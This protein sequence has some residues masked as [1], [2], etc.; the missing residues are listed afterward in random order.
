MPL[1]KRI[2]RM[3]VLITTILISIVLSAAFALAASRI[4]VS[5]QSN[6]KI[7]HKPEYIIYEEGSMYYAQAANGN[8]A[9]SSTN[10]ATVINSAFGNLTSGRTWQET[11]Y[12]KG[13]FTMTS[14]IIIPSYTHFVLDGSIYAGNGLNSFILINTHGNLA[15]ANDQFI[16][17]EGGE[18]YGNSANQVHLGAVLDMIYWRRCTDSIV[19]NAYFYD[20][21]EFAVSFNGGDNRS[22]IEDCKFQ[23][24]GQSASKGAIFMSTGTGDYQEYNEVTNCVIN[25]TSQNGIYW[26]SESLYGKITGCTIT[27]YCRIAYGAGI[28]V[29]GNGTIVSDCNVTNLH[30]ASTFGEVGIGCPD[31]FNAC[32]VTIT[33]CVITNSSWDGMLLYGKNWNVS[34]NYIWDSGEYGMYCAGTSNSI[35]SSNQI[36]N[37]TLF[38]IFLSTN[39]YNN[40]IADNIIQRCRVGV[41]AWNHVNNITLT[42]NQISDS[43]LYDLDVASADCDYWVIV[44]NNFGGGKT[45]I[46]IT[47]GALENSVI[48]DNIGFTYP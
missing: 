9:F 39:A 31:G 14:P 25:D 27:D 48:R 37:C 21:A 11:V 24:C 44:G 28:S 6:G 38:G 1:M 26:G 32:N 15:D 34:N 3:H 29:R 19:K 16:T 18:W 12:L 13:N 17:V 4:S 47:A 33:G 5:F 42:N 23:H 40:T 36:T 2:D 43:S 7:V 10:A 45:S 41:D 20:S 30:Y 46:L 8:I 35:I 22:K